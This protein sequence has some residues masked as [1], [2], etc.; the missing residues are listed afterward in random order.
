MNTKEKVKPYNP[1][2]ISDERL[3]ELAEKYK[4][5]NCPVSAL[6]VVESIF[7]TIKEKQKGLNKYVK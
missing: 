1:P 7:S 4:G 2:P 3:A 6:D 5:D